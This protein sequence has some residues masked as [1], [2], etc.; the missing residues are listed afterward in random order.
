ME[1]DMNIVQHF[2][3]LSAKKFFY[4]LDNSRDVILELHVVNN[5][6]EPERA[7]HLSNGVSR[8][9]SIYDLSIYHTSLC[10]SEIYLS[11]VTDSAETPLA[12][13]HM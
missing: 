3:S 12:M 11:Y 7:P 5:W 9:L 4:P 8:D 6:S 2:P 10:T 1:I 13:L